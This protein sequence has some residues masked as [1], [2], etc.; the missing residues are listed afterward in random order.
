MLS[1]ASVA[2]RV[3][4]VVALLWRDTFISISDSDLNG[5]LGYRLGAYPTKLGFIGGR[6]QNTGIGE[7]DGLVSRRTTRP[8]C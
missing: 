8:Y 5:L 6:S 4:V 3:D 1:V 7:K 2:D